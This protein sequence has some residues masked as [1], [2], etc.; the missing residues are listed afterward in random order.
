MFITTDE[1]HYSY[2]SSIIASLYHWLATFINRNLIKFELSTQQMVT[3]QN[4]HPLQFW[5]LLCFMFFLRDCWC[6]HHGLG[7]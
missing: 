1:T 6:S 4:S 2:L 3:G 5:E 7:V